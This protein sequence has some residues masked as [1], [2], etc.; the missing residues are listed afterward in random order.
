MISSVE[1]DDEDISNQNASR[2][3]AVINEFKQNQSNLSLNRVDNVSDSSSVLDSPKSQFNELSLLARDPFFPSSLKLIEFPNKNSFL[4]GSRPPLISQSDQKI[5]NIIKTVDFTR[6]T[7]RIILGGLFW[8]NPSSK[9]HKRTNISD[10]ATFLKTRFKD[11]F[12][13][14]NL[15]SK[16][17]FVLTFLVSLQSREHKIKILF[18]N[19]SNL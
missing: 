14:W 17:F 2:M 15:A 3:N 13:I 12:M 1:N 11:S 5:K 10:G 4:F 6:V 16:S 8:D 18:M 7:N 9:K 19:D